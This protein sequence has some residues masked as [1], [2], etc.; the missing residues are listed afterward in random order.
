M[1][2]NECV[3]SASASQE[4]A[5]GE[6]QRQSILSLFG[7]SMNIQP[8]R[9]FQRITSGTSAADSKSADFS[10]VCLKD[11]LDLIQCCLQ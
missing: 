5:V 3:G 1:L 10:V 7:T 2:P 8:Q 4:V 11:E 9:V 6:S